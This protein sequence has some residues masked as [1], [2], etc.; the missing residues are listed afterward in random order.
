MFSRNFEKIAQ[1]NLKFE[2][3]IILSTKN[4]ENVRLR[5]AK[6]NKN[7]RKLS[8]QGPSEVK[9]FGRA[10]NLRFTKT[11]K[12]GVMLTKYHVNHADLPMADSDISRRSPW[13]E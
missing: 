4:H 8:K 5:R 3:K 1:K 9:I 12:K 13:E 2:E 11:N 7:H 6:T 10:K